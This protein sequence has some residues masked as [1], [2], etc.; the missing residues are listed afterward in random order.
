MFVDVKSV[1]L[2]GCKDQYCNN[3]VSNYL[4]ICSDGLQWICIVRKSNAAWFSPQLWHFFKYL[5]IQTV[6][7]GYFGA[8]GAYV[9]Q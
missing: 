4:A 9:M 3:K 2:S 6:H 8:A 5:Y 1:Y 7:R